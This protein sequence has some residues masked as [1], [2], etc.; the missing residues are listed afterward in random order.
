MD[1]EET[2]VRIMMMTANVL[3]LLTTTYYPCNEESTYVYEKKSIYIFKI[4]NLVSY[5][6]SAFN[7]RW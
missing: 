2:A 3:F 5:K 7:K 4:K 1:H 6:D